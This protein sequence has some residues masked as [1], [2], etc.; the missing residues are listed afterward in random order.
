MKIDEVIVVEGRDDVDAVGKAVEAEIIATHGYGI[1]KE[2][3]LL[4][5]KAAAEKG[6]IVF[7]DPDHAGEEIRKKITEKFPRSKQAY[8]D[9]SDAEKKG[10]IGIENASPEAIKSA[11]EKAR[12]TISAAEGPN[13]REEFTNEDMRAWGLAGA[14][15]SAEKRAA[16]GKALGIG[17]ANAKA[18]LKRL[19]GFGVSREEIESVLSEPE[20]QK[21]KGLKQ[22]NEEQ[23]GK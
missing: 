20:K 18:L 10:D 1:T 21:K 16:L 17:R 4:L 5:E 3:W 13:G 7:T 8:L 2:T 11:L 19:N 9:R 6:L 12:A 22:E 23:D 15:D 14:E